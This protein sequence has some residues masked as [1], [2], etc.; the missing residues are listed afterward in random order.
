MILSSDLSGGADE[1][2]FH[3]FNRR[4]LEVEKE[5]KK[6]KE[7]KRSVDATLAVHPTVAKSPSLKKV[8][9]VFF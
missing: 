7:I 4:Q 6:G 5:E 8:K 3:T 1:D 9:V 2:D